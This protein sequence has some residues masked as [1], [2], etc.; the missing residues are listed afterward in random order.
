MSEY[1][2]KDGDLENADVDQDAPGHEMHVF[3]YLLG[4]ISESLLSSGAKEA[5]EIGDTILNY[6]VDDVVDVIAL[7]SDLANRF[8]FDMYE[9]IS[10][11]TNYDRD[12]VVMAFGGG[13]TDPRLW[14]CQNL[15]WIRVVGNNVES[16]GMRPGTLKRAAWALY[17]IDDDPQHVW[18]WEDRRSGKTFALTTE[19]IENGMIS[20]CNIIAAIITEDPDIFN[21]AI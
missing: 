8:D 2:I 13:N 11:L 14:A 10:G 16:W 19:Q 18:D 6:I 15:G 12:T 4:D 7:R 1:W 17:E 3:T 5:M 20:E 9:Y 21:G